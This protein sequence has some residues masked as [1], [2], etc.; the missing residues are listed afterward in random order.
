[1]SE[2]ELCELADWAEIEAGKT[3]LAP[4]PNAYSKGNILR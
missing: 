4:G 1:M 2:W 3:D